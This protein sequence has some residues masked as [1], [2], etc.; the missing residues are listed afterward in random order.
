MSIKITLEAEK[1]K[2]LQFEVKTSLIK[3]KMKKKKQF[4]IK[5]TKV[6]IFYYYIYSLLPH[7]QLYTYHPTSDT[8]SQV[9]I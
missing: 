6:L 1:S 3:Q 8:E 2:L 7:D 4:D 9:I 5:I